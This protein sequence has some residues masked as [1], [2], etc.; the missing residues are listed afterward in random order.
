MQRFRIPICSAAVVLTLCGKAFG[1]GA[2]VHLQGEKGDREAFFADVSVISDRTPMDQILGP[3]SVREIDLT[4]VYEHAAKPEWV[5]MRLQF[6]CPSAFAFAMEGKEPPINLLKAGAPVKF[7]VGPGSY[8]MRRVDLQTEPMPESGWNSSSAA[9]LMKAG[10]IACNSYEFEQAIRKSIKKESETFDTV[11]FGNAITKLDLPAD[12]MLIGQDL[13]A[14]FLDFSWTVLWW[15]TALEGKRPDPS[16][17]WSRL[18]TKAEKE[19]AIRKLEEIRKQA[20]PMLAEARKSLEANIGQMQAEFDFQDRAAELREGRDLNRFEA[21]LIPVWVGKAEEDVVTAMGSPNLKEAGN[22]R[23]LHYQRFF[24]NTAQVMDMKSGE[25][26]EEGN[27]SECNVE[28]VTMPDHNNI[29][30]VADTRVWIRE[31]AL[32]DGAAWCY[33]FLQAPK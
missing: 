1:L 14:E 6:E 17:K 18:A 5:T 16:G 33:G 11:A 4:A 29:W 24:D 20:E 32:G 7:K 19:A 26:W 15:D 23:F 21:Q 31:N 30:R 28:F 3:I 22:R 9:M 12:L 27:Y 25:T 13:P 2:I 8:L 10:R